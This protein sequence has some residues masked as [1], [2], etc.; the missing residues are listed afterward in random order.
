[1]LINIPIY[2]L[3]VYVFRSETKQISRAIT[4]RNESESIEIYFMFLRFE[5][6]L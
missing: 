1:M 5:N 6:A 2:C 4:T 3:I